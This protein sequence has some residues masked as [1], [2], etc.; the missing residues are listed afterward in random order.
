MGLVFLSP[1][2]FVPDARSGVGIHVFCGRVS[3]MDFDLLGVLIQLDVA[4]LLDCMF[5]CHWNP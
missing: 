5:F 2:E 1:V 4:P 3:E